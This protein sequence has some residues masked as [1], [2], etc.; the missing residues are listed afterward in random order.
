MVDPILGG[1]GS[2]APPLDPPLKRATLTISSTIQDDYHLRGLKPELTN[3][4]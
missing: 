3:L 4:T 2:V 1:G